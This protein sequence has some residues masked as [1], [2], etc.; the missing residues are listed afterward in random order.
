MFVE[1]GVGRVALTLVTILYLF[2]MILLRILKS[3]L[4]Y[5]KK[6]AGARAIRGWSR[7]SHAPLFA[8]ARSKKTFLKSGKLPLT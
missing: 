5:P 1:C 3:R 6:S 2:R 4:Q 8:R 7:N